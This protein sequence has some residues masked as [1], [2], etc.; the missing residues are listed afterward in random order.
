MWGITFWATFVV[1]VVV[2][3]DEQKTA[4]GGAFCCIHVPSSNG[5]IQT[6]SVFSCFRKMM[7]FSKFLQDGCLN[8]QA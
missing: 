6:W 5:N 4:T 2:V 8:L 1:V 3:V 7:S